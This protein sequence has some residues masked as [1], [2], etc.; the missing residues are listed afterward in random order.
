MAELVFRNK[1]MWDFTFRNNLYNQ[2]GVIQ[3]FN[4][5]SNNINQPSNGGPPYRIDNVARVISEIDYPVQSIMIKSNWLS[6]EDAGRLKITDDPPHVKMD[7]KGPYTDNNGTIWKNGRYWLVALHISS[8]D[9]PNW[10]WATFEHV[11]NPGRC[12]FTGCNDSYGYPSADAKI[13]AGQSR[14]YTTPHVK[15]DDLPLPSFVFDNGKSYG[16]AQASAGLS[17]VFHD[18]GIGANDNATGMP[19]Y[20]DKA[21]LNYRLKGSQVQFSDSMGRATHLANSVTEGGFVSSSSCMTCHARAG[22]AA[23]GTL[24]PALGVFINEL[25]ESGYQR[26]A[27]GQPVS[28]WYHRSGQPPTLNVLQT[29]FIWGFLSANCITDKC[30]PSAAPQ[31]RVLEEQLQK[32]LDQ[33]PTVRER[34]DAH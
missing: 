7:I 11:G 15:C 26:S 25:E 21:W 27:S 3:V 19:S 23:G 32:K 29:D 18:L 30:Q 28:D 2:E 10:V 17:A 1:P 5:N 24:P 22:T 6:E 20:S 34:T 16:S 12:D 31:F 13:A 33:A 14:N 4:N 8:K 9:I